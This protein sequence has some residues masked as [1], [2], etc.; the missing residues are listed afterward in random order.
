[1]SRL[2]SRKWMEI[3]LNGDFEAANSIRK[4][5]VPGEICKF[6][7]LSDEVNQ[8]SLG[9]LRRFKTLETQ[10]IWV[11]AATDMND[12]YEFK[13]FYFDRER[14]LGSG[15]SVTVVDRIERLTNAPSAVVALTSLAD[16]SKVHSLP[17]WAHYANS[18][19]GYCIVYKVIDPSHLYPVFYEPKPY[20]ATEIYR[21]IYNMFIKGVCSVQVSSDEE[22]SMQLVICQMLIKQ[23]DWSYEHEVRLLS[24]LENGKAHNVPLES[25]GL[26]VSYVIAGKDCPESS[27]NQLKE[28]CKS[29]LGCPLKKAAFNQAEYLRIDDIRP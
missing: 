10:C 29:K 16:A 2:D 26:K 13:G 24:S 19:H 4:S 22:I 18:H 25:V 27:F 12:P 11:S 15:C 28:I 9:D 17:M 20:D 1:M 6:V 3:L 23:L 14:A 8:N 7:S 21:R 5:L